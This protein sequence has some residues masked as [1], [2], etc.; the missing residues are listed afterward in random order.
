MQKD[1]S[2]QTDI[3]TKVKGVSDAEMTDF[4]DDQFAGLNYETTGDVEQIKNEDIT[5]MLTDVSD[6]ELEAYLEQDNL[7]KENLN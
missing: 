1:T 7:S 5:F 4:I 2:A 6:R 3:V